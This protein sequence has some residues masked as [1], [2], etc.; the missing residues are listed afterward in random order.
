MKESW[1]SEISCPRTDCE[2]KVRVYGYYNQ[3]RL[4]GPPEQCYPPEG[5]DNADACSACGYDDWTDAELKAMTEDAIDSAGDNYDGPDTEAERDDWSD[6][7]FNWDING[8][9]AP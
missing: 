4:S 8:R 1:D 6:P 5:E 3:G 9:C 2:G 7:R